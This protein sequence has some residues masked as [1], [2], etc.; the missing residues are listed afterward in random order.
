MTRTGHFERLITF[1]IESSCYLSWDYYGLRALHPTGQA[2]LVQNRSI[3][4]YASSFHF[5]Q[6]R[7]IKLLDPL[8]LIQPTIIV[9]ESRLVQGACD[10]TNKIMLDSHAYKDC[11][12]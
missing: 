2:K 11:R 7:S 9:L 3:R 1:G 6:R 4:F 12:T 5:S 10:G 8:R